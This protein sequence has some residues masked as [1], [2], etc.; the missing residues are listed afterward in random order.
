MAA[1]PSKGVL[2]DPSFAADVA[3]AVVGFTGTQPLE[4]ALRIT[5][6]PAQMYHHVELHI[7]AAKTGRGVVVSKQVFFLGPR[8]ADVA[9]PDCDDMNNLRGFVSWE[10]AAGNPATWSR[11]E[12]RPGDA[13]SGVMMQHDLHVLAPTVANS[14][15]VARWFVAQTAT[16]RDQ[17][18]SQFIHRLHN[19]TPQIEAVSL[20]SFT[21]FEE[22]TVH[23]P[24]GIYVEPLPVAVPPQH[25]WDMPFVYETSAGSESRPLPAAWTPEQRVA[26]YARCTE[27]RARTAHVDARVAQLVSAW[28][29]VPM[30]VG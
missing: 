18:P 9:F 29:A 8:A 24:G 2:F 16:M 10:G 1:H 28:D 3:R 12:L 27:Y 13:W 6:R 25:P 20:S 5:A 14:A 26:F 21:S 17:K 30:T 4:A 7:V 19:E 11:T 15:A 23:I 22:N